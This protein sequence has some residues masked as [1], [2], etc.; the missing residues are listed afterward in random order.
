VKVFESMRDLRREDVVLGQYEGYREVDGVAPDS[1]TDTFVAARLFIDNWRWDGVPFFLRTGK[2]MARKRQAVTLAFRRPPATMFPDVQRN[3]L[4]RDQLT[5]ELS[6]DEGISLEFLA[7]RPGPAIELGKARMTFTYDQTFSSE[8]I[9]AYER[10]L[11][12]ALLGDRSLFTRADGIARTWE[13]VAEILDHP[14]T[15][16]PYPQ[17]SWGPDAAR[18]LIAPRRWHLPEED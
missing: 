14:P 10:L 13:V 15:V 17:G 6:G 1:Q 3:G 4:E 16:H 8:L 2:A 5:F 9:E 12:D 11:H 7:K 18:E